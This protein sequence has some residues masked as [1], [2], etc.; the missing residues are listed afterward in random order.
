MSEWEAFEYLDPSSDFKEDFRIARVCAL[1]TNIAQ[2]VYGKKGSRPKQATATDFMPEYNPDI[3][4]DDDAIE[5]AD[6]SLEDMKFIL[7]GM[8]VKKVKKPEKPKKEEND[9]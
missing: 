1:I 9:G 3:D 2:S 5:A 7:A 4:P 6:Q 8:A